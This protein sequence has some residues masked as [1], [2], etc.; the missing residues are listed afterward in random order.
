M[1]APTTLAYAA[2]LGLLM[3]FLSI[4]VPLRRAAID[5]P[6][7][8]GGDTVLATRIRVFGNFTE[9]VPAIL[10]LMLL[11][12]G[13]GRAEPLVLHALGLAL[14]GARLIHAATLRASSPLSTPQKV[15]R[16][17][18]AMLTWLVLLASASQALWLSL[19]PF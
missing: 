9:Y 13:T 1:N 17:S 19:P 7:G 5:T 15:G 3:S 16:G 14:V 11:A 8:D 6:W 10:V 4:R 18:G 2:V 12:E